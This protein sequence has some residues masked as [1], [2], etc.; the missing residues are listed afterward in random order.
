MECICKEVRGGNS[1]LSEGPS[2]LNLTLIGVA[3]I[4]ETVSE[5]LLRRR[6]R[7]SINKINTEQ[8]VK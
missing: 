6:L 2:K 7:T 1:F 8:I 4:I 3:N 5:D